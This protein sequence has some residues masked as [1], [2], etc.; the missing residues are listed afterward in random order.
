MDAI[1]RAVL[2][3]HDKTDIG[4]LAAALANYGVE[5]FAT[6]GTGAALRRAGIP[7]ASIADLT[8]R[9]EML[10]GRVK[11][12][13]PKVHAGLLGIRGNKLHEEEMQAQECQWIDF[14]AVNL[15]PLGEI[16]NR[17]ATSL[18]E[19]MEEV[20]IGGLAMIRSAAKNFRYVTV[21]VNP[22][23][24][25]SIIHELRAHE[26][27]VSFAT[28]FRLAQEAFAATAAYDASLAEYLRRI[29]PPEA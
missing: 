14:V 9:R 21:V 2:S 24:Y 26:G 1:R 6:E 16:T 23:R 12:L 18:D 8:G 11:T 5:T 25:P 7:C 15:R 27:S 19:L 28:R 22:E 29:E 20:D 3:C 17:A 13:H 4:E 10:S